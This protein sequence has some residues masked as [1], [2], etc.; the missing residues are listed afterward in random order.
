MERIV[1]LLLA[2]GLGFVL[3]CFVLKR[4]PCLPSTPAEPPR[5]EGADQVIELDWGRPPVEPRA[6]PRA[7]TEFPNAALTRA[8][9]GVPIPLEAGAK[10]VSR[11]PQV[12]YPN[13]AVTA[14][15]EELKASPTA[16]LRPLVEHPNGALTRAF[17]ELPVALRA[18]P[19]PLIE[20]PSRGLT[21]SLKRPTG[22]EAFPSRAGRPLIEHVNAGRTL[23]LSPP[24]ELLGRE[25]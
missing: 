20:H 1:W 14:A 22:V 9:E 18:R 2:L 6:F 13:G 17:R 4:P 23:S 21:Y 12:E 8:L 11:R 5:V 25:E 15:L 24:A 19:R 16:K 7:V 10:A 3:W